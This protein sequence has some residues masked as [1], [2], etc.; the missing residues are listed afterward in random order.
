MGSEGEGSI[1]VIDLRKQELKAGS[2]LWVDTCKSVREALEEYGCFVALYDKASPQLRNGLSGCLKD[3][4]HLPNETKLRNKYEGIPLKGYVGQNSRLPLHESFGI[5]HPTTPQGI[6]T[7]VNQMWPHGNHAFCKYVV[8]YAKMVEELDQMVARMIFESYGGV[9]YYEGYLKSATYLLRVLQ[10]KAPEEEE[11]DAFVSHTDKSF[12]TILHQLNH[13]N[14]LEVQTKDGQWLKLDFSSPTSFVVM[15]GDAIMAWSNDRI[16]APIHKVVMNRGSEK[17]YSLAL[18]SFMRGIV[19]VN[20]E[21]V[22]EQHPLKYKSFHH[23]GLL[24]FTYAA[25]IKDYCGL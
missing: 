21:L 22:D 19:E 3:L 23:L 6:Q 7:F 9:K 24:N 10:H 13:V 4:F 11:K 25:H 16:Q 8:E 2:S 14:A 12:T 15:A 20:E 18:F 5:D 17:R 1:P